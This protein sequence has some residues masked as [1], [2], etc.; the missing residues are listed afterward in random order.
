MAYIELNYGTKHLACLVW[1][2]FS[3]LDTSL[4]VTGCVIKWYFFLK[5][6]FAEIDKTKLAN[7]PYPCRLVCLSFE[8]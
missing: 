1:Q 6:A 8:F 3:W 2:A 4:H 7:T 5:I